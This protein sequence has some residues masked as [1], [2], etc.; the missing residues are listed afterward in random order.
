MTGIEELAEAARLE[1]ARIYGRTS[2]EY[3]SLL[4][5]RPD[6]L[7]DEVHHFTDFGWAPKRVALRLGI[8][9]ARVQKI[10]AA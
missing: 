5:T 2:P 1:L 8:S 7:I 3:S 9:V 4:R 6:P 10:L